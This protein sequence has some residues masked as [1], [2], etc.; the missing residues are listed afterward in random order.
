MSDGVTTI[1][2]PAQNQRCAQARQATSLHADGELS[3][4]ETALLDAHLTRCADCRTFVDDLRG[5]VAALRTAPLEHP[6]P[7]AIDA[8]AVRSTRAVPA[9]VAVALV[10]VAAVAGS[11]IGEGAF[12]RSSPRPVLRSVAVVAGFDT[13]DQLRRLRRAGLIVDT[14]TIPRNRSGESI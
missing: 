2:M 3:T 4:L 14:T 10:A 9:F 6:A 1:E 12:D 13:P 8:P 11:L 5:T 7:R